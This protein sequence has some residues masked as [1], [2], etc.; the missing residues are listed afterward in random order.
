MS[1]TLVIPGFSKATPEE[2]AFLDH[3]LAPER[4]WYK[5]TPRFASNEDI[6]IAYGSGEL[7]EVTDNED[8]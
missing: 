4:D 8:L 3:E 6:E 5:D 1:S 2:L 7:V